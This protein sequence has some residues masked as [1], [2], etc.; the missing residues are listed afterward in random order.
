MCLMRRCVVKPYSSTGS[1]DCSGNRGTPVS[2]PG[3]SSEAPVLVIGY[4]NDLRGDDGLGLVVADQLKTIIDCPTVHILAAH[5]LTF[6]L[7]ELISRARSLILIDAAHGPVPGQIA[8]QPITPQPDA[9]YTMLHHMEAD[10]LLACTLALYET[11]PPAT[12]WTVTGAAFD[13]D[14]TLSPQ[15]QAALPT[16]LTQLTQTIQAQ[17]TA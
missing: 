12:L 6:D 9:T 2:S 15:V 5:Q 11:A 10:A 4:G 1:P 7:A 8:C 13:Y 3:P 14:T 17:C 16:F